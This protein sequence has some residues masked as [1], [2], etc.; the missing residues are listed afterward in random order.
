MSAEQDLFDKIE[1]YLFNE[2]SEEERRAFEEE[3]ANDPELA[4]EVAFHRLEHQA[5]D[6]MVAAETKKQLEEWSR[7]EESDNDRPAAK[8]Q[9]MWLL[10]LIP[11]LL[12]LYFLLRPTNDTDTNET[13][14]STSDIETEAP[15]PTIDS[16]K[17]NILDSDTQTT[18]PSEENNNTTS[19][20][21]ERKVSPPQR[22]D[23]PVANNNAAPSKFKTLVAD[24]IEGYKPE[25][26]ASVTARG[27]SRKDQALANLDSNYE[28]GNYEE[29]IFALQDTLQENLE[30]Q[31]MLGQSYL[32]KSPPDFD[33]AINIFEGIIQSEEDWLI[34]EMEYFYLL[35]LLGN[36]QQDTPAFQERLQLILDDA[37]RKDYD[38]V[39]ALNEQLK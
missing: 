2:L 33:Q 16:I 26:F 32:R 4:E 14:E 1:R 24:L 18:K 22:P 37:N 19:P 8:N 28:S 29:V 23:R 6:I 11:V 7:V 3:I 35:A 17:T 25:L 12:G 13:L 38:L 27:N 21:E 31:N 15:T 20:S 10:L 34:E 39:K 9:W 5:M 36:G 30:L